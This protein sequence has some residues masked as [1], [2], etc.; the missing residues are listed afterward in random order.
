[1]RGTGPYNIITANLGQQDDMVESH[2]FPNSKNTDSG[3]YASKAG[4]TAN[5]QTT[6]C[7]RLPDE[8]KIQPKIPSRHCSKLPI[9]SKNRTGEH[10]EPHWNTQFSKIWSEEFTG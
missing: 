1:M 10:T 3:Y 6:T 4:N 2:H 5:R 7:Y 9:C 8:N